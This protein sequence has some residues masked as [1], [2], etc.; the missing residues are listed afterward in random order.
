MRVGSSVCTELIELA[1]AHSKTM[2][3]HDIPTLAQASV[4]G[5]GQELLHNRITRPIV[6]V[7]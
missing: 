6:T 7:V 3:D 4:Q 1:P 2:V 5:Q